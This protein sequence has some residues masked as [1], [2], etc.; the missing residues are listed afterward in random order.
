MT[1]A[2]CK[3]HPGLALFN[4]T[5]D[6][7]HYLKGLP[8]DAPVIITVDG[9]IREGQRIQNYEP[10]DTEENRQRLQEYV[11]NLR[12][13]FKNDRRVQI[14]QAYDVGLLTRNLAMAMELVNTKYVLVL[15]HDLPFVK[16]VNFTNLIQTMEDHPEV[17]EIVRFAHFCNFVNLD[18]QKLENEEDRKFCT[19]PFSDKKNGIELVPNR[20]ADRNHIT[21]KEYYV[22]LLDDL[23]PTP[24]FMESAMMHKFG[25]DMSRKTCRKA[26]QWLY[27]PMSSG[28]YIM[29][30]DGQ[31]NDDIVSSFE[32]FTSIIN[33]IC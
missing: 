25:I 18:Y 4:I 13:K 12:R 19:E 21:T 2:L 20:F 17:V 33:E 31:K 5:F 22:K 15:Q 27:G 7:L 1:T 24:R 32:N 26:G 3:S 10:N 29:H 6:S 14:L 30:L 8:E 23:G 28:P 9:L 11:M 16:D